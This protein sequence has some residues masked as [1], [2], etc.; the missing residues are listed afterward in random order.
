MNCKY[1][2]DRIIRKRELNKKANE[3]RDM[4]ERKT[5]SIVEV[6]FIIAMV[7]F[8]AL[9]MA[10]IAQKKASDAATSKASQQGLACQEKK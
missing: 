1:D 6:A 7:V 2:A 8:L 4:W 10:G 3:R 9:A 5:F